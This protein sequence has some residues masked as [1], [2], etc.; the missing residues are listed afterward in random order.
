MKVITVIGNRPQFV[1]AAAVSHRLR[2]RAQEILVHTGQHY[3]DQLSRVF[4]DELELPRPEHRL[5]LGGGSNT[6]Q[7][8][9]MLAALEP[10]LAVRGAGRGARLRRH[11]LD[12]CRRAGRRAGRHSR[13]PRRGGDALLRPHDAGGAQPRARRPRL[14]AAAV[15]HRRGGEDAQQ[16]AGGRQ[17]RGRRRR[18]GRRLPAARAARGSQGARRAGRAI[19][20]VPAGHRAPRRQRRRSRAAASAG[21]AA[22]RRC[23]SPSSS[24]CTRGQEARLEAASLDLERHHR[25][26]R[27]SATSSSPRCCSARA[28][29]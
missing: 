4:F 8:A 19:R 2:E 22:A 6:T 21:R 5:E 18:D 27:R 25:A 12:A 17:D 29:C 1:K 14:D 7:T 13:R 23:P 26:R 15:L 28:A 24:R 10:L 3:D 11:E 16:R 20:R 9:R